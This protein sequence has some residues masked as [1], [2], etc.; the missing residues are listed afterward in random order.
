M[1]VHKGAM[2]VSAILIRAGDE[3]QGARLRGLLEAEPRCTP[4]PA[5]DGTLAAVLEFETA[6]EGEALHGWLHRLPG[7]RAVDVVSTLHHH[8]DLMLHEGAST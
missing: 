1:P 8:E 7:V 6:E 2:T 5:R 4:G 3:D